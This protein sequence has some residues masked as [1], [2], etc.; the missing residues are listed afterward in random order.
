MGYIVRYVP[1]WVPGA[2]FQHT[3]EYFKETVTELVEKPFAFVRHQVAAGTAEPSYV[4]SL[5][6]KYEEGDDDEDTEEKED[7]K[8]GRKGGRRGGKK[9][10]TEEE[11]EDMA[12]GGR[13]CPAGVRD[14]AP[15]KGD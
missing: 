15:G 8:T 13:L 3:A 11:E 7:E 4:S 10:M 9:R 6:E 12:Q 2:G 5:L 1:K 14:E